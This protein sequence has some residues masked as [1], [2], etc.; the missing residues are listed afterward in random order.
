MNSII[1]RT[2]TEHR[3]VARTRALATAARNAYANTTAAAVSV[4]WAERRAI[5]PPL[6]ALLEQMLV[7]VSGNRTL[8]NRELRT[9]NSILDEVTI[10]TVLDR[11]LAARVATE[12]VPRGHEANGWTEADANAFGADVIT[13]RGVE[14]MIAWRDRLHRA[15]VAAGQ[16]ETIAEQ[17][18][19]FNARAEAL[20]REALA[21]Y[22]NPTAEAVAAVIADRAVLAADMIACLGD[23]TTLVHGGK[24]ETAGHQAAN[25]GSAHPER[26]RDRFVD[27][28]WAAVNQVT[29]NDILTQKLN[30]DLL[31]SFFN[32]FDA[33]AVAAEGVAKI[34]AFESRFQAAAAA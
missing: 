22:D 32:G 28:V 1:E 34:A 21:A 23:G 13:E 14:R 2:F 16:C 20:A 26:P 17:F 8:L 4:V 3:I 18:T 5:T 33:R 11:K 12:R 25:T 10:S 15:T 31:P 24:G 7:D 30:G 27:N 9:L 19:G 6:V 29:L